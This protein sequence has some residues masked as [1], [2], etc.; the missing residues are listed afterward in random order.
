[1]HVLNARALARLTLSPRSTA[2]HIRSPPPPPPSPPPSPHPHPHPACIAESIWAATCTIYH[3]PSPT[4]TQFHHQYSLTEFAGSCIRVLI[5]YNVF[6]NINSERSSGD[7]G[8]AKPSWF[9]RQFA[10]VSYEGFVARGLL[11]QGCGA[12]ADWGCGVRACSEMLNG[13]PPKE[14]II[15]VMLGGNACALVSPPPLSPHH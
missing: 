3:W 11:N 4:C 14:Y 7:V 6:I 1:M 9:C 8:D 12:R 13:L 15:W 10:S 2:A 5:N